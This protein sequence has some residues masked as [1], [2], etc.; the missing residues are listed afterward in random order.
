MS[1][2]MTSHE[3]QMMQVIFDRQFELFLKYRQ[4]ETRNGFYKPDP[5]ILGRSNGFDSVT[6]SREFQGWVKRMFWCITEELAEA[7]MEHDASHTAVYPMGSVNKELIDTFHFLI[8]VSMF[9]D[10]NT[11]TILTLWTNEMTMLEADER[12]MTPV[13]VLMGQLVLALGQAGHCLKNKPWK[14]NCID[15]NVVLFHRRLLDVWRLWTRLCFKVKLT[16]P[17][18]YELYMEKSEINKA[19]QG[20]GY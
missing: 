5:L 17:M 7:Q 8:E 11:I 13:D 9:C 16:L 6:N 19:R 12:L 15:T 20:G 2:I 1:D 10:I 3:E 14:Q 4:I 18:L